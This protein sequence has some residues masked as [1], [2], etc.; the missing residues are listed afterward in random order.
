[1]SRLVGPLVDEAVRAWRVGGPPV[2]TAAVVGL[3]LM[4]VGL[5]HGA[6]FLV[7]GGAWQGPVA[8]RKPFAFGLSF[9][10]TAVTVAWIFTRLDVGRRTAWL[11]LVPYALASS[12]E[13]T[14]VSVQRARGVPSHFN[15]ATPAD[16]LAFIGGGVSVSLIVVVLAVVLG[17]AWRRPAAPPALASAIRSGLA[18]LL[19]SQS[20]GGVMIQRGI[21]S[22]DAGGPASHAISP[23][24]DLKVSHALA[25]HAIQVLGAVALWLMAGERTAATART[26]VRLFAA[27]YAGVVTASLAQAAT[28]RAVT[29]Q[30]PVTLVLLAAAV[31]V[32][33]AA[34]RSARLEWP[35]SS[36]GA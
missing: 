27:G 1:M 12:V 24:G 3:V 33:A 15:N 25:M 20:I 2:R 36:R 6:R 23:A 7:A 5:A 21:A 13:V 35:S 9:G 29:D 14:W 16:E 10:L 19:V 28:G 11:L 18:I 17:L 31:L 4:V 22:L 32:V 26:V 30:A 34:G 8:W